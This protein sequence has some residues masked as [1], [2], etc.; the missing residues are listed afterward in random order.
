MTAVGGFKAMVSP[1]PPSG[2][3]Y[4]RRDCWRGRG[5]WYV[6]ELSSWGPRAGGGT[7][8]VERSAIVRG[9]GPG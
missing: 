2:G 3:I 1:R 9:V 4:S 5:R 6:R 7:R 8:S